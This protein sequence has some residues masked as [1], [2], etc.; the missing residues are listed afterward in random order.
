MSEL[1][2]IANRN[3]A[4]ISKIYAE[5]RARLVERETVLKRR[6]SETLENEHANLKRKIVQLEDQI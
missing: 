2:D 6:I 4:Q 3:R 5:V 1:E